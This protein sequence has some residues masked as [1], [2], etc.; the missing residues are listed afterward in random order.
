MNY[1]TRSRLD[2][3]QAGYIEMVTDRIDGGWRAYLL[4]FTFNQLRGTPDTIR[5]IM[6][7]EIERMYATMVT[8]VVRHP[9]SPNSRDILPV[10]ICIPDRPV[11]KSD[12]DS[13][14]RLRPNDGVHFHAIAV[15]PLCSRTKMIDE[16]V[17]NS[18][19]LYRGREGKVANVHARRIVS[20]HEAVTDYVLKSLSRRWYDFDDIFV[21]PRATSELAKR[22]SH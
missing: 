3:T 21:L 6:R 20:K 11:P 8:R 5:A 7:R 22:S 18:Q 2:Q 9:R 1:M 13:I 12:R 17:E 4:T 10:W 14:N 16:H 15:F 19:I